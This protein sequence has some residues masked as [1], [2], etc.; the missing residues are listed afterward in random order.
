MRLTVLHNAL[1]ADEENDG[2]SNIVNQNV[3]IEKQRPKLLQFSENQRPPYWGTWRKRS[4][5][6]TPRRPFARDEVSEINCLH[7]YRMIVIE[8]THGLCDSR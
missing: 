5:N 4:N 6:I 7:I 3:I 2:I 8:F 1:F